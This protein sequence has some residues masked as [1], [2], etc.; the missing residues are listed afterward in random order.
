FRAGKFKS[1]TDQFSRSD[2]SEQE[3]EESTAWLNA[4]WS[5][6]QAG[7]VKARHLE[8]GAIA[9]YANQFPALAKAQRGDLAAAALDKKLGTDLRSRREFEEQIKGLVG[10]DEKE[11]TFRAVPHWD[12]LAAVR[13]SRALHLDGDHIGVVVASGEILDGEQPPGTVGSDSVV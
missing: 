6:Y 7:V 1:Y 10:E 8:P 11:H 9:A 4:L 3:E 5:Q 13:P 2:M 12:Y